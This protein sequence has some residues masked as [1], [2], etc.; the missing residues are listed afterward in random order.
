L[1]WSACETVFEKY[2]FCSQK[3]AQFLAKTVLFNK[4]L[5]SIPSSPSHQHT[6]TNQLDL[7]ALLCDWY[8]ATRIKTTQWYDFL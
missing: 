8:A 5:P 7:K 1:V 2:G 4:H 6:F 3:L